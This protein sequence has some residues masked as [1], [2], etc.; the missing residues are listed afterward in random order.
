MRKLFTLAVAVLAS[1]SMMAANAVSMGEHS[2][3]NAPAKPGAS[4]KFQKLEDGLY[5]YRNSSFSYDGSKGIKTQSNNSGAVFHIDEAANIT[6]FAKNN[7]DA[8]QETLKA[9]VCTITE[10]TFGEFVA[11]TDNKTTVTLNEVELGSVDIELTSKD[12]TGATYEGLAEGYYFVYVKGAKSNNYFTKF[13][14]EAAAPVTEPVAKV[15]IEGEKACYVGQKVTLSAKTDIRANAYK[16][17][18]D[19]KEQEGATSS[20]FEF[21][22]EAA[23]TFNIICSAKN[24]NNSDWV[25]S[26]AFAVVATVK[27]KVAQVTVDAVTVWDWTKAATVK[28]IKWGEATNPAKDKDTV[29]L[30]NVDGF[31]N[32]AE[33]NSQA[34]LFAG[35]YPVRDGKYCQGPFVA[36]KTSIDG[37]VKV[38]FSNTGGGDRPERYV[39]IN[40]VVNKSV[41]S[42]TADKVVSE[43]I[44]VKAGEVKIQ[45]SFEEYDPAKAQYLRIYKI[46]FSTSATAIENT[47]AEVKAMKVVRDGQILIIRDGKTYTITGVQVQ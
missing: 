23:G 6:I 7:K 46:T 25:A 34:L 21:T 28:E 26:E 33:F 12:E 2:L 27:E 40:G 31:N 42:K 47:A 44:A 9:Y 16:W 8:D 37:F 32:N 13:S 39:A 19:G 4:S 43:F 11:G 45:G 41:G 14:L 18:V 15:E 17:A 35:E 20:S 29:V 5:L 22:P 30:A 3:L 24:D 10:E 36:F 1:F 38:E